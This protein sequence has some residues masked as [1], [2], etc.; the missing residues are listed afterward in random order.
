MVMRNGM[1]QSVEWERSR[2]ELERVLA[3]K[4]PGADI[5]D[6]NECVAGRLLSIYAGG[7]PVVPADLAAAGIDW[8]LVRGFRRTVLRELIRVP[9]GE[10]ITY[11]A[12]GGRCGKPGA[13]RAAG[14]AVARNPWPVIVPCHRVVGAGGRMVGFGKG[15]DAKRSL[16]A[17]ERTRRR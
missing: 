13:A 11:G 8:D 15:I 17:F 7:R 4:Y 2:D 12:L 1:V 16:L 9:Y 6:T 14:A 10:T 5:I 3:D